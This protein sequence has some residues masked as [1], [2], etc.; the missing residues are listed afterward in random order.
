MSDD[1]SKQSAAKPGFLRGWRLALIALFL[2]VFLYFVSQI[3]GAFLIGL[4]GLLSHMSLHS[5]LSWVDGSA[6]AQFAL[7]LVLY[8]FMLAGIWLTLRL[9]RWKWQTIGLK[10][11]EWWHVVLG[12]V[13]FA[14]Y[15]V[16]L[17]ITIAVVKQVFFPSLDL[18]QKQDIGFNGVSGALPL[19]F[20]FVSLVVIPPIVEEIIMRGFLYTSLKKWLPAVIAAIVVSILFGMAH[21]PEGGGAGP[22][23]VGAIDTFT[24]SM[25]LVLLREITGNLWAGITLH[26]LK[27]FVAFAMLFLVTQR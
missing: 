20:A 18:T 1:S 11:P 6:Y 23:W 14:P 4:Y 15:F 16:L 9:F 13:A 25:V 26:A 7:T 21:L 5:A 12:I 27:N 3:F 24:L 10:T 17:A 2:T 8:G 22:L 19:V